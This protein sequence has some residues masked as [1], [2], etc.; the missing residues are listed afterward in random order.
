MRKRRVFLIVM[1]SFGIGG[2]PD[3]AEYGDEGS[4][5]LRAVAGSCAFSAPTLG[6]LG[7]FSIPGIGVP[8]PAGGER[9]GAYARLREAS[10]GKDTTI[11]HWELAG[12]ISDRPL[13]T[14]PHGFPADWVA[15]FE[16]CVGRGTL[17]NAPFSGTEVIAQFGEEHMRTGK[18]IVYT[19]ADSVLQ[20]AAHER[21]VPLTEL[22][23]I[24][25]T[26]RE[27]LVGENAVGRVIARPFIGE[28]AGSFARTAHRHDY[29]LV[30]PGGTMLDRVSGAG[31]ECIGVG[32]I[33]DIF[34]GKGITQTY[35]T[36]GNQDGMSRLD[37]IVETDFHGL[38]F[39]NLVDF[40][41]LYGHRNDV[42]GYAAAVSEFDAWLA[43]F[44]PKLKPDD[45][46]IITADH[47]CDPSTPSTDHS[48]ECVPCLL[49]GQ[50]VVPCSL[51]TG[52]TFADI[53]GTVLSALGLPGLGTGNS[54]W[55]RANR[56]T[57][58]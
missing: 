17:C 41:M 53:A 20:I 16:R 47:G 54:L 14:Y 56:S 52:E 49:Y 36:S 45:L 13:P 42:D 44:L 12:L 15:A 2:A 32:K 34:A 21:I 19:S 7:L 38:C 10:K 4:D 26:A 6:A 48:R 25:Q 40:D 5:T 55:G 31:M 23:A 1:D 50:G 39:A 46:L 9:I 3:A 58:L 51:G 30:P 57:D 18:L 8:S 27:M 33:N 37:V 11:G 35:P 24:C 29:S 43:L 22:Y 28:G